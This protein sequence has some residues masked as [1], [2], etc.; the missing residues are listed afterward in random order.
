MVSHETLSNEILELTRA[1]LARSA[2]YGSEQRSPFCTTECRRSNRPPAYVYLDRMPLAFN[3]LDIPTSGDHSA[4]V[5][6]AGSP[7]W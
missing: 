2:P 5:R 6:R 7:L 3:I 4:F 1:S